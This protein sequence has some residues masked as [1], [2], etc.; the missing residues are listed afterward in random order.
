MINNVCDFLFQEEEQYPVNRSDQKQ[1]PNNVNSSMSEILSSQPSGLR[2]LV[3]RVLRLCHLH[4]QTCLTHSGVLCS[5]LLH[6]YDPG[7]VLASGRHCTQGRKYSLCWFSR[8]LTLPCHGKPELLPRT[9]PIL[10]L[11]LPRSLST[12]TSGLPASAGT[13]AGPPGPSAALCD[14]PS[15]TF[16]TRPRWKTIAELSYQTLRMQQLFPP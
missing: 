15:R 10:E 6:P 13:P 11:P 2:G 5:T 4:T 7:M 8:T 14:S 1:T 3:P 12:F 16:K 9:P